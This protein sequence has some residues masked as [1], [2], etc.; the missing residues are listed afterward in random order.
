MKR[1]TRILNLVALFVLALLIFVPTASAFDGRS[2]DTVVIGKDEV[3]NDDLFVAGE[4]V[5]VDGT[6]N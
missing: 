5:T 1:K 2:G 4:T 3:I 6:V